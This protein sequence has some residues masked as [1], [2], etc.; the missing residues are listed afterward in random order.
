MLLA[1]KYFNEKYYFSKKKGSVSILVENA[2][3]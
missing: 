2:W 3:K 1:T